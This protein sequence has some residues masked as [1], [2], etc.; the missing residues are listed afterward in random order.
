VLGIALLS[1]VHE[2]NSRKLSEAQGLESVVEVQLL[3]ALVDIGTRLV[4]LLVKVEGLSQEGVVS[5]A[6]GR[7]L[8]H[9][10]GSEPE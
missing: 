5:A 7:R 2:R 9:R 8:P 10:I 4:D 6:G 3:G 1:S